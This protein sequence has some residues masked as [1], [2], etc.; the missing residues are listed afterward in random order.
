MIGSAETPLDECGDRQARWNVLVI[1]RQ[2]AEGG[3]N[4]EHGEVALLEVRRR[5]LDHADVWCAILDSCDIGTNFARISQS[6][7]FIEKP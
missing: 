6:L 5:L 1:Q 4:E 2:I 3:I 7:C